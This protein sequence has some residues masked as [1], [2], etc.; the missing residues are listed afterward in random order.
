MQ[1][2]NPIWLWGLLGLTVPIAIHL[3]SRKEGKTIRIGSIRHLEESATTKFKSLRL[4]E[5][6]LLFVRCL[7]IV[8]L[9]FVLSGLHFNEFKPKE[10]WLVIE[11]SLKLNAGMLQLTDSLKINGFVPKWLQKDF[12]SREAVPDSSTIPDYWSLVKHLALNENLEEVIV[13][14]HSSIKGFRGRQISIP[15]KIRWITQE[16]EEQH[17]IL[18][19]VQINSDTLVVRKGN[20]NETRTYFENELVNAANNPL[21]GNFPFTSFDTIIISVAY[22]NDYSSDK[23]IIVHAL[24]VIDDALPLRF[25]VKTFTTDRL[26]DSSSDWTI[27]LSTKNMPSWV[28]DH[29]RL[30]TSAATGEP[31]LRRA[32]SGKTNEW[33]L[34]KRLTTENVITYGFVVNLALVLSHEFK[35]AKTVQQHDLRTM[36]EPLKWRGGHPYEEEVK[37]EQALPASS[38]LLA[39]ILIALIMFERWLAYKRNQ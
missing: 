19:A 23:E 1:F 10:K 13:I 7:V 16:P 6:L 20:S 34:T 32:P 25:D 31:F 35:P 27:W 4:N 8:L 22:D 38:P 28:T 15:E 36:P 37:K 39:G 21:I 2:S 3:L 24:K 12:P 9:T 14:S 29:I 11:P 17:F 18:S 26:P 30:D 5:Y 33:L